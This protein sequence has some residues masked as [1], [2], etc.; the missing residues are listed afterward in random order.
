MSLFV[1]LIDNNL[2][3]PTS[4]HIRFIQHVSSRLSFIDWNNGIFY[5][6][7]LYSLLLIDL[8]HTF[9]YDWV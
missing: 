8:R 1:E 5:A 9:N 3:A 2:I 7:L 6:T 4:E